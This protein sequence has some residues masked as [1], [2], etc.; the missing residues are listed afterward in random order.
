MAE[1][2]TNQ[3][4]RASPFGG[5]YLMEIIKS[6]SAEQPKQSEEIPPTATASAPTA[7]LITSLLSNPDL[8]SKLPTIISTVKPILEML[9]GAGRPSEQ[10]S[11]PAAAITTG[12]A[13]QSEKAHPKSND[14]RADLLCALKPYLSRDRCEAI[15][16][17]VKLSRLGDILK[18][19]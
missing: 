10:S 19:L 1:F 7:D 11:T 16:Y 13:P 6:V 5:D 3:Q 15:D 18:T 17:I 14:R 2:D 12:K 4:E 8:I 9:G